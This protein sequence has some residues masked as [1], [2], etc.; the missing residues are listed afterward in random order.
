MSEFGLWLQ[1]F[2]VPAFFLVVIACVAGIAFSVYVFFYAV[3][4]LDQRDYNEIFLKAASLFLLC[5]VVLGMSIILI[6][7]VEL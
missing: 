2:V 5:S 4:R 7:W 3:F 1:G 6:K